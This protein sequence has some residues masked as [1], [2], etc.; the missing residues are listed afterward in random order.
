MR[1]RLIKTIITIFLLLL[2]LSFI[3]PLFW[4]ALNSFKDTAQ[5]VTGGSFALPEAMHFENYTNALFQNRILSYMAN[6]IVITVSTILLTGLT[7]SMA[8]FALARMH[9]KGKGGFLSLFSL[10]LMIPSQIVIVPVFILVRSIGLIDTRLSLVLSVSAFNFSMTLLISYSFLRSLPNSIEEAA[11]IDGC[12]IFTIFARITLPVIKSSLAAMSINVFL[13]SWNE[14]MFTLVLISSESKKTL[15]IGL[16]AYSG[17]YGTDFGG[18]F[19]AMVIASFI[20]LVFFLLFN[21]QVE[22]AA[23]ASSMLK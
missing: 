2:S 17:R 4:L 15:P 13:Q 9:W 7:A 6:S 14:F 19:A 18:M 10:G 20:P 21:K 8:A 5:I 22:K 12:N 16:L 3:Y 23:I 1:H 11:L